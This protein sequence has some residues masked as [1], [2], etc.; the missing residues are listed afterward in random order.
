[1]A[2][3]LREVLGA[4]ASTDGTASQYIAHLAEL[5]LDSLRS[6][7]PQQLAQASH[8]LLISLQALSKRSHKAVV[9][10][11]VCHAS[12]REN[13][14]LISQR[15]TELSQAVPRLDSQAESFSTA[16]SKASENKLLARRKQALRLLQN[17]ERLVDVMELPPLLASAVMTSPVS[18]S[19]TLD[20]YAHIRR[21]SS[22]YPSSALV[23]S[24]LGEADTAIRQMAVD[25]IIS[26]KSPSLKLAVALHVPTADAIPA[27]FLVCRLSTLIETLSAL[28]PLK[29]LADEERMRQS[30]SASSWSGGQ[31][32]E[33]YLKTFIEVFREH[34]FAIVSIFKSLNASF[35]PANGDGTDPMRPLPAALS[36]LPLHL[37]ELLLETLRLYLPTVKDQASRESILTQV[38]YC[39][40]SMGRLGADFGM[41]LAS[42]GES[43]WIDIVK[44]HRL[45]AGRLESVIG[46]YRGQQTYASLGF[47]SLW[48]L[49]K[50]QNRQLQSSRSRLSTCLRELRQSPNFLK[51]LWRGTVPS[52]LRTGLGTAL[53]FS[54]L[55]SIRQY[56]RASELFAGKPL[57]T[58]QASSALPT[59][60][61]TGNMVA[62]SVARTF[63]G[64]VLMPL[65]VVKRDHGL[66][67]FFAG[68]GATALRDAPYAGMYVL[69]YEML[70]GRISTLATALPSTKSEPAAMTASVA[71][72]I[73]FTSAVLAG[74]ACSAISNPFDAVKTRIQLQ[75]R[76]YRNILQAGVLMVKQ[77][78]VRSLWD[79]LALRMSRKALSSALAWTLYE[80]LIRRYESAAAGS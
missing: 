54:S 25:L 4:Q 33:R 16:F 27:L 18:Y 35:S 1:M 22:L 50:P 43:E 23:S 10:S 74:A 69:F 79:G 9:D 24:V 6:S 52:A 53:Y 11:E 49:R 45:L 61:N 57:A 21:L 48:V 51:S 41:L 55:N 59:L 19:S 8:S 17:S 46:D 14:P 78:G 30:K 37:V 77:D 32:T 47:C 34:S 68:F 29:K 12:L 44:R 39:A 5:P 67:G 7:E 75:P 13:L 80:E 58:Q 42:L 60:T 3:L 65:T 28:D 70:K 20:L 66:R 2:D 72:S 56:A 36:S 71:S 62:G 73:N 31:Q 76:K 38:L 63:A 64:F 40:G 26:L 15:A